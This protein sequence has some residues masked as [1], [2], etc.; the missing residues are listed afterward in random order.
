MDLTV[1]SWIP[2]AP[3]ADGPLPAVGT[4]RDASGELVGELLVWVGGGRL[5][6][7]ECSW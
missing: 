6:A 5:S 1:P 4:V 7:L 3:V 2:A